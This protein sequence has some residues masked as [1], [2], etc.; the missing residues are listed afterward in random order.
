MIHTGNIYE[1]RARAARNKE[2]RGLA[3]VVTNFLFGGAPN[4]Q[5]RRNAPANDIGAA[6]E[7]A[8]TTDRAA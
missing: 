6:E 5:T 2:L 3:R 7:S 1:T 8:R 4:R